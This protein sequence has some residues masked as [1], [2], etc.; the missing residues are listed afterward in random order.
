MLVK[1]GRRLTPTLESIL[2]VGVKINV[3]VGKVCCLLK[4]DKRRD[5]NKRENAKFDTTKWKHWKE[6]PI[7]L[8]VDEKM[9]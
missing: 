6:E 2:R 8:S 9:K 3:G 4:F 5:Q 1:E 7:T